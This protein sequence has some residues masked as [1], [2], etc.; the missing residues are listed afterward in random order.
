M[1]K[2]KLTW[3]VAIVLLFAASFLLVACGEEIPPELVS[4]DGI[5]IEDDGQF[6]LSDYSDIL[7]KCASERTVD[8]IQKGADAA[9]AAI[10]VWRDVYYYDRLD[11]SRYRPIDPLEG[12]GAILFAYDEQNDCWLVRTENAPATPPRTGGEEYIIVKSDGTV[13]AVWGLQ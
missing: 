13:M 9:K 3:F 10:A 11:D 4:T 5:T 1:K 8:S 6:L 2:I 12:V 7:A